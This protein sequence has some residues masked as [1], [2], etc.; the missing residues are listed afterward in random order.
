MEGRQMGVDRWQIINVIKQ[1]NQFQNVTQ[2]NTVYG[3]ID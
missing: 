2:R 1:Y 3:Q